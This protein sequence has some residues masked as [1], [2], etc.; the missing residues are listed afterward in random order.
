MI[1]LKRLA[2][3]L[4]VICIIC[5]YQLNAEPRH[6]ASAVLNRFADVLMNGAKA[7]FGVHDTA[8]VSLFPPPVPLINIDNQL[9]RNYRPENMINIA[10]YVRA[11]R[12]PILLEENA[13][14]AYI[15]MVA[16][17]R[18]Y[19]ITDMAAISGFRDWDHQNRLHNAQIERHARYLPMAEARAR[20]A[21][22]VAPPGASEH[23]SGLAI[24]VSSAEVGFSLTARFENTRSFR[25][26]SENAHTYGFIIRYPRDSTDI[27]GFIFEPWHLR[28]VG[29]EHAIRIFEAGVTLEEYL[30]MYSYFYNYNDASHV[31]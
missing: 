3:F 9:D 10:S 16:S 24:D 4:F 23:Q 15:R 26:L 20:A 31:S 2:V 19:G 12:N 21:T 17:M 7:Y 1:L 8:E 27:T 11:I 25:W 28:Y 13:A 22:I 5:S 18:E 6:G 30:E 29:A 14:N